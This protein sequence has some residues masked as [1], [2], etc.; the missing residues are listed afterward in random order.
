MSIMVDI[1]KVRRMGTS[2][3][4]MVDIYKVRRMGT[5]MSIMVDIY[6]VRRMGTSVSIMVNRSS[7]GI[8]N[9]DPMFGDTD[10]GMR[11]DAGSSHLPQSE[12]VGADCGTSLQHE[13]HHAS[14]PSRADFRS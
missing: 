13:S 14:A 9:C 3:S 10:P 11:Y 12:V 1:Y 7:R 4:I 5:S 2:M 6:K 8:G